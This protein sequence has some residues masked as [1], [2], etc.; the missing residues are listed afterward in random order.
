M[1]IRAHYIFLVFISLC[2]FT[3]AQTKTNLFF[4]FLP[5]EI[6]NNQTSVEQVISKIEGYANLNPELIYYIIKNTELRFG[7]NIT[8]PKHNFKNILLFKINEYLDL[9]NKW[10]KRQ[11][12]SMYKE[13]PTLNEYI[14]ISE[15]YRP[16]YLKDFNPDTSVEVNHQTIDK[17]LADFYSCIYLSNQ[18]MIYNPD[19][20]YSTMKKQEVRNLVNFFKLKYDNADDLI[21]N[22]KE[23]VINTALKYPFL[24]ED[25]YLPEYDEVTPFRL[26][27]II[28]K[29]IYTEY[30]ENSSVTFQF[31]KAIHSI[32]FKETITFKDN[33]FP[34]SELEGDSKMAI[35]TEVNFSIG[36]KLRIKQYKTWLS[37]LKAD[38]G[39][40]YQSELNF[41]S[42]FNQSFPVYAYKPGNPIKIFEGEY[43]GYVTG[44]DQKVLYTRIYTP[45]YYILNNIYFEVGLSY[46]YFV[47][48][49]EYTITRSAI[50]QVSEDALDLNNDPRIIK[51]TLT[52]NI[53][54]PVIS[55]NFDI[56]KFL[57]LK[58]DALNYPL[59]VSAGIE[60]ILNF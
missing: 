26:F 18:D 25:T 35:T 49:S 41:E 53:I 45:V 40:A 30:L 58:I 52:E 48:N 44:K 8:D 21:E 47:F 17:N 14:R 33:R 22:E 20:N 36:V 50:R 27:D 32:D 29:M 10:Y 43:Q 51:K 16:F 42:D 34:Y 39:I 12:E 24:F 23:E 6:K 56:F 60:A 28:H 5:E 11:R 57:T 19:L 59:S 38:I 31:A 46:Y 4:S 13:I 9:R 54:S 7:E 3:S 37:Y 55:V 1:R 15:M 2:H